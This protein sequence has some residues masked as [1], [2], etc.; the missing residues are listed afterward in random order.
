MPVSN[1][2]RNLPMREDLVGYLLGALEPAEQKAI[3]AQLEQDAELRRDL[4][5]LREKLVPLAEDEEDAEPPPCLA[6]RTCNYVKDRIGPLAGQ[7][8]ATGDWRAQDVAVAGGIC[9]ILSMLV[10]P[11]VLNSRGSAQLRACQNNLLNLG[12][13]LAQ[14]SQIHDNFFPVVPT[15]GNLAVAGMY[16]PTLL[17]SS[18][19]NAED[20]VCPASDLAVTGNFRVPKLAEVRAAAGA[21]L[22]QL[23]ATMGGSYGYSLGYVDQGQYHGLR[24]RARATFAIMADAPLQHLAAGSANHGCGGQNVLFEDGH[25]RF[26]TSCTLANSPDHIF[27]NSHGYVGAGVGPEDA[28]VGSSAAA[29]TI[30]QPVVAH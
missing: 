16:A 6:S 15:D 20:L 25:V 18:L 22:R 12:H 19:I 1:R 29:P 5:A 17:D 30:L 11:A 7:F 26:L 3:E 27:Q 13:A 28:V 9:L 14:Y 8:A 21:Q 23:Q 4:E 10:F 2:A 24:N